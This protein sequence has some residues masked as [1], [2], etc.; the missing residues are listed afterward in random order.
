MGNFLE[1]A[2]IEDTR[3]NKLQA[4]ALAAISFAAG[5]TSPD[6][7]WRKVPAAWTSPPQ[8]VRA[9][10]TWRDKLYVGT[11]RPAAGGGEIYSLESSGL[12]RRSGFSSQRVTSLL[13]GND[14]KLYAG[15]GT[16]ASGAAL[17]G[18]FNSPVTDANGIMTDWTTL[19]A[20]PS[21]SF[22]YCMTKHGADI[23]LGL[24]KN[25]IPGGSEV[26][27]YD[28]TN[29]V[30]IGGPG[31][32][33]WPSDDNSMGTYEVWSE[34][35]DLYAS[36]FS[37][38]P[39][40]GKILKLTPSGWVSVPP[41][42][43]KIPLSF[44]TYEGKLVTGL[45]NEAGTIANPVQILINGTWQPLGTAPAE[46]AGSWLPNHMVTDADG[47]L[48][49]A[50]GGNLGK[51]SVWRYNGQWTKLGGNG[52]YGSWGAVSSSP[53]TAE[54]FYRAKWHDGKLYVGVAANG[55]TFGALWEMTQ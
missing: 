30:K 18:R 52:L 7:S 27:K 4:I 9:L 25:N 43:T 17:F 31:V 28:G 48:T 20:F 14:D 26:W 3:L 23:I 15:V 45:Q 16:S 33:G 29:V 6:P 55:G 13:A 1:N 21:H 47:S 19:A 51:L 40:H 8:M 41:P 35:G 53:A 54:W 24:M 38:Y 44:A 12:V 46:W 5:E 11:G 2:S 49:V 22:V 42:A 50:F 32:N 10:D 39:G 34:S 36:T 37:D